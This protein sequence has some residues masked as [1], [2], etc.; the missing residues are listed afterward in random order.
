[1]AIV[2]VY[3]ALTNERPYKK[4]FTHEDSLEIIKSATGKHFDPALVEVFLAH[5]KEFMN[6]SAVKIAPVRAQSRPKPGGNL[7]S[8]IKIVTSLM[9]IHEGMDKES[10]QRMQRYLKLFIKALIKHER[11]KDEI[12]TW[13]LEAFLMSAQLHDVGKMGVANDILNKTGKLTEDEFENVKSHVDLGVKVVRQ[14]KENVG[15][16]S[17]MEHA[18]ALISSHHERW[19]GTGYPQGLK[20]KAIPLQGRLMAIIDVYDALTNDRPYREMISHT[21][22]IDAIK[23]LSGT[24]FDPDLVDVFLECEEEFEKAEFG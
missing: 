24:H 22:A 9:D 10:A 11:F 23:R 16:D 6:I 5:E 12:L 15:S 7:P 19:D 1:M 4:A 3:D 20:G 18:E 13:N 17:V 21:D 8:A 14:I 2:D